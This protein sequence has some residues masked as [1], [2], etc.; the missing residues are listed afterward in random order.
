MTVFTALSDTQIQSLLSR[1]QLTLVSSRPISEGI[2]NSNYMLEARRAN[3]IPVALVLTLFERLTAEQL[4]WFIQ[5]THALQARGLPVPAPLGGEGALMALAGKPALLVPRLPGS[6]VQQASPDQLATLG[7]ALAALHLSPMDDAGAPP[8]PEQQLQDLSATQL[9]CL[10]EAA[11]QRA[12]QLLAHWCAETAPAVLCHGD[13]FRDNVL[14]SGDRLTGLLDFYNA[15]FASAEYD[16]AITINDWCL[17]PQRQPQAALQDALLDGYQQ[18]RPLD[19]A[20]RRRLPLALAI[21]ALRFW[22]SRLEGAA[23]APVFGPGWKDPAEF[24]QLFLLRAAA[25]F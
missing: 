12:E 4:P 22:L 3:G 7:R 2:E 10:P 5:L 9:R 13:L 6:H 11:R 21:A 16:L 14:F 15:G 8:G 17:G 25:V 19:S 23:E 20:A 24:E 18:L 1:Q